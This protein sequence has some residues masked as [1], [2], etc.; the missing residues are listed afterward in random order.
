MPWQT[1]YSGQ[2]T[3]VCF[4]YILAVKISYQGV[5]VPGLHMM[6]PFL[7]PHTS[8]SCKYV[9][10]PLLCS[11]HVWI[12]SIYLHHSWMRHTR[13]SANRWTIKIS[14]YSDRYNIIQLCFSPS[15]QIY[16]QFPGP[17]WHGHQ[18]QRPDVLMVVPYVFGPVTSQSKQRVCHLG[19]HPISVLIAI[20]FSV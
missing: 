14:S 15:G 4:E 8:K 9:F 19:A 16:P 6:S 17:D 18:W 10:T 3:R 5:F 1:Q 12:S 2:Y 20:L 13:F 11:T 7:L